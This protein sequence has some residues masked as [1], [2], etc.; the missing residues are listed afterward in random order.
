ML[1]L[2]SLLNDTITIFVY[3]H[4]NNKNEGLPF[5]RALAR[6]FT[7]SYNFNRKIFIDFKNKL[8]L[9]QV[10]VIIKMYDNNESDDI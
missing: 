10:Y 7:L 8:N 3:L 4:Y 1:Y 9:S 6:F 5:W 2:K